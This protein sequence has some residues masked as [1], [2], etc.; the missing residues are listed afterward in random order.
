MT[1]TLRFDGHVVLVTGA[2]SGIGETTARAF[3]AAG[4]S[5][6][7]AGRRRDE[8]ERI[9]AEIV[10]GGGEATFAAADVREPDS[11]EAMVGTVL[12]TYGRLDHAFNN[13]GV[14]DRM[15]EFHT[16][17]DSA[18][19]EMMLV[20]TTAVFQCMK[21][22]IAAMLAAGDNVAANRCIVNNASTVAHRGSVRAS[23][24]YVASK[25]A[26]LGLTRQAAVEYVSR[27]IRVNAVSPGPTLTDVSA[28]LVAEGPAAVKA[29]LASLNPT[30]SFVTRE[31][32]AGAVLF[33]CSASAAMINGAALPLDG[34]QLAAL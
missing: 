33:L 17:S 9:T 28:P 2:T 11:I 34:G 5:V 22:E 6:V 15:H 27:G 29:A 4:A 19:D 32:V 25:H 14:F 23:P 24:A 26:V 1:E 21:H 16:Y 3:A 20:N 12:T 8:G 18:W 7:L 10:A 31:Q 30:G 13:A